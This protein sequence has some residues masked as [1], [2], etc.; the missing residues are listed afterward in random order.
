M[1]TK[2][3]SLSNRIFNPRFKKLKMVNILVFFDQFEPDRS[4]LSSPHSFLVFLAGITSVRE[5][6]LVLEGSDCLATEVMSN[7]HTRPLN[8]GVT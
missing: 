7:V 2:G 1:E 3:T 5:A 4:S 6:D 8:S